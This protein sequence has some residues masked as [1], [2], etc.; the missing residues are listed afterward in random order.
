LSHTNCDVRH[1]TSRSLHGRQ[2]PPA[3]ATHAKVAQLEL[4]HDVLLAQRRAEVAEEVLVEDLQ[5]VAVRRG[6]L[7]FVRNGV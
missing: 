3:R 1:T 5:T 6:V 7:L 2:S 4:L